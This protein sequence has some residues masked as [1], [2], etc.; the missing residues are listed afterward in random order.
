MSFNGY[1]VPDDLRYSNHWDDPEISCPICGE[2]MTLQ[3]DDEQALCDNDGCNHVLEMD[4]PD[5]E[6]PEE[7][8]Y[9]T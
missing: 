2:T 7:D 9:Y 1:N 6:P 8:F 4:T 5:P 3:N